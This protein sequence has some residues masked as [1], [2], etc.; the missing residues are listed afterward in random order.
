MSHHSITRNQRARGS[1][2]KNILKVTVV[3]AVLVWLLYQ[4][5]HSYDKKPAYAEAEY[6]RLRKA[7]TNIQL[8]R[9]GSA[10]SENVISVDPHRNNLDETAE[11]GVDHDIEIFDDEEKAEKV[12]HEG[13]ESQEEV[14]EEQERN[15]DKNA[16]KVNTEG[17]QEGLRLPS[18]RDN[19]SLDQNEEQPEGVNA[20]NENG[21]PKGDT[22][23]DQAENGDSTEQGSETGQE[24]AQHIDNSSASGDR[25]NQLLSGDKDNHFETAEITSNNTAEEARVNSGSDV[26]SQVV[27]ASQEEVAVNSSAETADPDGSS[28]IPKSVNG[29]NVVMLDS[30]GAPGGEEAESQTDVITEGRGTGNY[31]VEAATADTISE[32]ENADLPNTSVMSDKN[33]VPEGGQVQLRRNPD[34]NSSEEVI[35]D[36]SESDASEKEGSASDTEVTTAVT[37]NLKSSD[38][39]ANSSLTGN[40]NDETASKRLLDEEGKSKGIVGKSVPRNGH[41]NSDWP[42]SE[43]PNEEVAPHGNATAKG[44]QQLKEVAASDSSFG[45]GAAEM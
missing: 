34:D 36:K 7:D 28:E 37:V 24:R 3:L 25:S 22:T 38:E 20:S 33:G 17:K 41:S 4:S 32:G 18:E 26:E 23:T 44:E 39:A 2:T 8:G 45:N 6:N 40:H 13:E 21:L 42:T 12:G 27:N 19:G 15:E 35:D 10:G 14:T 1:N 31:S 16:S 5:K 29:G 11:S 43:A 9:K 30:N